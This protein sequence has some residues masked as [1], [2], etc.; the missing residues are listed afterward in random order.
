MIRNESYCEK[1]YNEIYLNTIDVTNESIAE[2][3]G[4]TIAPSGTFGIGK[5]GYEITPKS[6]MSDSAAT[7]ICSRCRVTRIFFDETQRGY[8]NVLIPLEYKY[9]HSLRPHDCDYSYPFRCQWCDAKLVFNR[10]IRTD[11]G[12]LI[13]LHF[14]DDVFHECPKKPKRKRNIDDV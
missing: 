9:G 1:C 10:K 2:R 4:W 7:I 11:K 14:E 13:P 8:N 3:Y 12:T 6:S 5:K